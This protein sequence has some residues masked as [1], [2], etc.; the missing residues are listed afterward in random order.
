VSDEHETKRLNP[1]TT[2]RFT[3][4]AT[5]LRVPRTDRFEDVDIALLGVPIDTGASFRTGMREG[6]GAVREA[7]RV[8]RRVNPGTGVSPFDLARIGD[9]GDTP[10]NPYNHDESLD[11]AT[12]MVRRIRAAGARPA[13]VGGDHVVTYPLIRGC[14]DGT[15]LA[16]LQFDSH[17]DVIDEWYGS[18]VNHGTIMRRAVEEGIVEPSKVVQVG[19]RGTQNSRFDWT[20]GAD[21]GFTVITYDE[22]EEIGR[23]ETIRRIR[24][25]IGGHP[26]YITYDI[27]GLDPV[28]APGTSG[29]E[30]GGLSMRDSQ[31]ILRSL[32]G[33]NIVGVDVNEV[34]P[35]LDPTGITALNAANLLFE[36]VCLMV[37]D[38]PTLP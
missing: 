18:R 14:H 8:I 22:F 23:A 36:M 3:D 1:I 28:H 34:L 30:P 26:V 12:E 31:V 17:A 2:P 9:V 29:R 6:P 19:L 7:S 21:T 10:T 24:E 35:M 15:P 5:L 37:S 13:G 11:A 20:W 16:V 27:D 32:H 38:S 4:V 25:V 33:L